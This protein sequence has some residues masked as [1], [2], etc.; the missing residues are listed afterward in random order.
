[1][2]AADAPFDAARVARARERR[3]RLDA[4]LAEFAARRRPVRVVSK[5]LYWHQRLAD[6]LLR[7]VTLGGQDRYLTEYVTTLGRTIYVPDHF[8]DG[9]PGAVWEVL[10]HE[11]VHVR[12]FERYGWILM[13]LVYGILPLP[14]GLAYGRAWLEWEAYE[15]T[16]RCVAEIDGIEAARSPEL[17]ERIVQRFTGPDY[18]WMWP[19]P[20]AVRGWIEDALVR[21]ARER[22]EVGTVG[23]S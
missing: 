11:A 8:L 9:E 6:R 14:V 13:V 4:L 15:E 5:R 3:A 22:S 16:L 19:F 2:S 12:Q 7:L 18:A 23:E 17:T 1:M 21:I 10:R 20:G